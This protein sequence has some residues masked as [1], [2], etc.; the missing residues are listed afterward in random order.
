MGV[1]EDKIVQASGSMA[2]IRAAAAEDET[3]DLL[4][5]CKLSVQPA[6]DLLHGR[7]EKLDLKGKA[8]RTFGAA[9]QDDLETM[10]ALALKV[11]S[12]L[13]NG[14]GG[15]ALKCKDLHKKEQLN[16]FVKS[17]FSV[18][19]YFVVIGKYCQEYDSNAGACVKAAECDVCKP[20]KM[21]GGVWADLSTRKPFLPDPEPMDG[22]WL[23]CDQLANL[24]QSK[25]NISHHWTSQ[26]RT[27]MAKFWIGASF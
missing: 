6:K 9:S 11:D 25:D 24:R 8:F 14:P 2:S 15:L 10:F 4:D 19:D 7:F 23:K 16:E 17:H 20:V 27:A 1:M 3:G 22:E 18:R 5:A 21:A 12:S 13:P 26:S